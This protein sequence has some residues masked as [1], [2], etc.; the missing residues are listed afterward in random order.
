[1]NYCC[2]SLVNFHFCFE[3]WISTTRTA[4]THVRHVGH[5]PTEWQQGS[6]I[7]SWILFSGSQV[8][9]LPCQSKKSQK[10][11]WTCI[12]FVQQS[13]KN[14]NRW[15]FPPWKDKS[16]GW[17]FQAFRQGESILR[18]HPLIVFFFSRGR[19]SRN[20]GNTAVL[21]EA[22][23]IRHGSV[24]SFIIGWPWFF[25]LPMS[26]TMFW[27]LAPRKQTWHWKST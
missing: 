7:N 23:G 18:F 22:S 9:L 6:S 8:Q 21:A 17:T 27:D 14:I 2:F 3:W 4:H 1:M 24:P 12:I 16:K 20:L 5:G 15:S 11:L 10:F 13:F 25:L 19:Y 26:Q